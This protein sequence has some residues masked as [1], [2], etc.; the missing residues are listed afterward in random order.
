M[1]NNAKY[2]L[3]FGQSQIVDNFYIFDS[4]RWKGAKQTSCWTKLLKSEL[5]TFLPIFDNHCSKFYTNVYTDS[6]LD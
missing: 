5:F 3:D 2:S 6:S 1:P 4:V